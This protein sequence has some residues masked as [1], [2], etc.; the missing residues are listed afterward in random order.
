MTRPS[1]SDE[2]DHPSDAAHW[3]ARLQSGQA[4]E[5]DHQAF[6]AWL[7]ADPVN[8]RRYREVEYLWRATQ[9]VPDERLRSLLPHSPGLVPSPKRRYLTLG[10]GALGVLAL[11]AGAIH[12][13]GWFRPVEETM[14]WLTAKGERQQITLP[15]GSVMDLNTDT[16]AQARV[17]A[18]KREIELLQG[19]AFFTVQHD[20]TLPFIVRTDLG[21]V[22]VTG[23]RFNVR[24]LADSLQVSVQSGSVKVQSG[25]WWRR[26][27]RLLG[28]QQQVLLRQGAEPGPVLTT[29]VE[30]LTAW[31]RGKIIFKNT[32]LEVLVQEMARYLPQP[33]TLDAPA[34]R[35]HRVSGIFDIDHPETVLKALPA[36]A[37]VHIHRDASGVQH[38]VAR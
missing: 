7:D 28:T 25:P 22:T 19:E 10:L 5:Q 13:S 33:L 9:A 4:N 34:L 18:S 8:K 12:Q 21:T 38:I 24:R 14:Q 30:S 20:Q 36:I 31:Q 15:D 17:S 16:I 11:S 27:E 2:L 26:Q 37:P 29:D 32:P 23:T 1:F 6:H 35:Q 3:F